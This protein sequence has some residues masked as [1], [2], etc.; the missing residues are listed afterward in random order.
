MSHRT[1]YCYVVVS[2]KASRA[3]RSFS[4]LL[5]VPV[6]VL[7]ISDSSIRDLWVQRKYLVVK[8][9]VVEKCP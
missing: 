9:G 3:L 6:L 7:I 2:Y 4:D 8:Q 1:G 5:C